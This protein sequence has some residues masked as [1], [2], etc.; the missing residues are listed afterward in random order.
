MTVKTTTFHKQCQN[1]FGSCGMRFSCLMSWNDRVVI[2]E[3][4]LIHVIKI[5]SASDWL[6]PFR[7]RLHQP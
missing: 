6:I 7:H 1:L 2:A 5:S 3:T 4:L